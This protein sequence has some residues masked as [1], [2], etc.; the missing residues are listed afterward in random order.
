MAASKRSRKAKQLAPA[1][2]QRC[3]SGPLSVLDQEHVYNLIE[4]ALGVAMLMATDENEGP[5][6][7][8]AGAIE[9]ALFKAKKIM[10]LGSEKAWAQQEAERHG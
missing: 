10:E 3:P 2:E 8:A 6:R 5:Q 4:R 7:W 9:E 1:V